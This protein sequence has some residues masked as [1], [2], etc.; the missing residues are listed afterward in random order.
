MCLWRHLFVNSPTITLIWVWR[1]NLDT[2]PC[3]ASNNY[4]KRVASD[5]SIFAVLPFLTSIPLPNTPDHFFRNLPTF[6]RSS[7]VDKNPS[8]DDSI[9]KKKLIKEGFN[10]DTRIAPSPISVLEHISEHREE[11]SCSFHLKLQIRKGMKW[12]LPAQGC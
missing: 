6:A 9:M 3:H 5:I 4:D 11:T 12:Y 2:I 1:N 8:R 7:T 10:H